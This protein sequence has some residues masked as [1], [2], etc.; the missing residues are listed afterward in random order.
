MSISHCYCSDYM[1]KP[2]QFG[3]EPEIFLVLTGQLFAVHTVMGGYSLDALGCGLNPL[4]LKSDE[5]RAQLA[6]LSRQVIIIVGKDGTAGT[7]APLP[8]ANMQEYRLA[9]DGKVLYDL[10]MGET[11]RTN[12]SFLIIFL[13]HELTLVHPKVELSGVIFKIYY[14][15][16]VGQH[17]RKDTAQ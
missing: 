12:R 13:L 9:A 2:T 4:L 6:A 15:K 16:I 5:L 17:C 11:I 10:L 8:P 14:V 1:T 3:D 7:V